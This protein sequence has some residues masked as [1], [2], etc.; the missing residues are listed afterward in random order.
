MASYPLPYSTAERRAGLASGPAV[1][2]LAGNS[3][4]LPMPLGDGQDLLPAAPDVPTVR[5]DGQ[6][7]RE[8]GPTPAYTV[9][10][11]EARAT[12]TVETAV[13]VPAL[14]AAFTAIAAGICAGL[15][16]WAM[17][18]PWKVPAV[19]LALGLALGW[20]W[21]LRFADS[22]LQ[23]VE[24]FTG[25]D[26]DGNGH[27]GPAATPARAFT[28]AQPATARAAAATAQREATASARQVELLEFVR[29]CYLSGCS[30]AAHGVKATGP[31]RE[32]YTAA[33]DT[34]IRLGVAGWRNPERPRGGWRML[35]KQ[36]EA[37][38]IVAR[39]TL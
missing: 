39:H 32:T 6:R 8:A 3:D 2:Y 21:R 14:Q 9:E 27:I 28:V 17:G 26:L 24:T 30:E 18:W 25:L 37:L 11:K 33:R 19:V 35:V 38:A 36:D 23:R 4:L 5:I 1:R 12:A 31:D 7:L 34:L 13:T 10:R 29:R 20:V 22:L 16:A 15:L